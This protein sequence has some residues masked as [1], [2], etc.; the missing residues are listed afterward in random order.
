MDINELIE[1]GARK[2]LEFENREWRDDDEQEVWED[3]TQ[4]MGDK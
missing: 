3:M 1:Y 2:L 4:P